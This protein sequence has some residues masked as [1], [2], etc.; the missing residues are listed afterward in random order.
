MCLLYHSFE[1]QCVKNSHFYVVLDSKR[2]HCAQKNMRIW[3]N[4][5]A[6]QQINWVKLIRSISKS[7]LKVS[8][9]ILGEQ[10]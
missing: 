6:S 10:I 7:K 5:C 8:L 3:G 4:S 1:G 2:W 9:V